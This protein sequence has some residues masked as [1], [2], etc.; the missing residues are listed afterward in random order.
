MLWWC[1]DGEEQVLM[2]SALPPA[3]HVVRNV[4]ELVDVFPTVSYMAGL[5]APEPCPLVSFK[6]SQ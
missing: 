2:C 5:D 1:E 6:V 3:G 4:V